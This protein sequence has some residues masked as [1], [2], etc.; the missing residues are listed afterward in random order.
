MRATLIGVPASHPTRAVELML[1][2]KGIAY[3]RIDLPNQL[4]KVVL[5][6]LRYPR[7]TVPVLKLDDRRIQGSTA[8][9]RALDETVPDPPLFPRDRALR[10]RVEEAETWADTVL[11]GAA[12]R[13]VQWA[14]KH[15][16][17]S[18]VTFTEGARLRLP[19]RLVRA[20]LP[21]LGPAI[22]ATVRVNDGT[23]RAELAALARHV[24]R[25]DALL[26]DGVVGGDEPNAADYQVA[27]SV[28]L[29]L[30]SD[31]LRPLLARRPAGRHATRL[32]PDYPGRVRP[33][34]PPDWLAPLRDLPPAS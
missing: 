16:R 31:D 21:L 24:E 26:A 12:R 2:R 4:Q 5:P 6:L 1:Q 15:D 13:V 17:A 20:S 29:L 25:V 23:A 32:V 9:A 27:T 18:L 19:P 33:V 22:M 30:A 28:R 34:F 14:T 11:Q 3:E 7:R 8:I 10:A